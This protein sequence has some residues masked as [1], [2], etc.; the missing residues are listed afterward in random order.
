MTLKSFGKLT[1]KPRYRTFSPKWTGKIRLIIQYIFSRTKML[2]GH[3]NMWSEQIAADEQE[4]KDLKAILKD[5]ESPF[6]FIKGF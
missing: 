1:T 3:V 6:G 5:L 2:T 4:L